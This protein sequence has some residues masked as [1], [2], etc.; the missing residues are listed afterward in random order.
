MSFELDAEDRRRRILLTFD[1][2]SKIEPGSVLDHTTSS[3]DLAVALNLS[4]AQ[5]ETHT[6][7]QEAVAS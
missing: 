6:P 4:P 2:L 5:P 1:P 7:V 3:Q